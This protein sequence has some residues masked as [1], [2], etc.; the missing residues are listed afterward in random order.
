[1]RRNTHQSLQLQ[2]Q[3]GMARLEQSVG[4]FGFSVRASATDGQSKEGRNGQD[5][6]SGGECGG[7][8]RCNRRRSG[9]HYIIFFL[10]LPHGVEIVRVLHGS[11]D[12]KTGYF[13]KSD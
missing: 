4:D 10:P 5:N 12:L 11:R 3:P 2:A 8:V 6:G 1:M 7:P 9:R 13:A